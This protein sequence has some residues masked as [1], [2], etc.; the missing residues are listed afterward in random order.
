MLQNAKTF[1]IQIFWEYITFAKT[2]IVTMTV[3]GA[4]EVTKMHR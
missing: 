2:L 3:F 4:R 1:G